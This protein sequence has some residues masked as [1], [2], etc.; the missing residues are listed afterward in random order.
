MA[1]GY[2]VKLQGAYDN[3]HLAYRGT[4]Q[5][6]ARFYAFRQLIILRL[7]MACITIATWADPVTAAAFIH[8]FVD[9]YKSVIWPGK[10]VERGHLQ[11]P[12]VRGS[13]VGRNFIGS[14]D[15]IYSVKRNG[16]SKGE[17]DSRYSRA[18]SNIG[19]ALRQYID[20][21]FESAMVVEL[22]VSEKNYTNIIKEVGDPNDIIDTSGIAF[23]TPDAN[24]TS[25][26]SDISDNEA[27]KNVSHGDEDH[28]DGNHTGFAPHLIGRSDI[29]DPSE[30]F[31][32]F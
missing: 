1:L 5:D 21:L 23:N 22:C 6:S 2:G 17:P 32:D 27:Y 20:V 7:A 18:E 4:R 31:A 12:K 24:S 9:E 15:G 30:E 16:R 14:L 19:R 25:L 8:T 26:L 3:L 10:E 11:N 29:H 28:G 13:K